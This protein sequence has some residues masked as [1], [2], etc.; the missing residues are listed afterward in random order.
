MKKQILSILMC[1]AL[2]ASAAGCSKNNGSADSAKVKLVVGNWPNETNPQSLER[3]NKLKDDFM[4]D[5][6]DIEIIPDTY[7]FDTKTFVM[8][9]SANQLPNVYLVP[10]T[11]TKQIIKSGYATPITKAMEKYGYTDSLNPALLDLVRGEDNEIYGIPVSAYA[12]GLYINKKLFTDAGLVNDDGSIKIPNTYQEM[13]EY[14]GIIKEKTGVAGYCIPTTNNCGGWHFLNIAWS[15]GVDFMEERDD[16]TWEAT[17]NTP[18]CVEAL[19]YIKD[20]K[21][22]YNA[23]PDNTVIDQKEQRK[24]FAVGQAGMTFAAPPHSELTA[25]FGMNKDDIFAARMPE[26]PKGRYTQMGGVI[27]MLANNVS[28]EQIDATMKWLAYLGY[29]PELTES[30][31]ENKKTTYKSTLDENG[32]VLDRVAFPIWTSEERVRQ[33]S[34]IASEFTNVNSADYADYY[35]FK[36][37]GVKPEEP[38]CCQQL[39]SILDGCIQEV[40]T[41]ENADCKLL[42][43]TAEKDFQVNH[44]DKLQ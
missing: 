35:S 43:E 32:I 19:Q 28:N 16:G 14:A 12:Q 23:L 39:Y 15:W 37:V 31:V 44:L 36:D 21:W 20:L 29:A 9:A 2:A 33:E 1:A 3:Q 22:K 18:E 6:P 11:E 25:T 27:W 40:I 7:A 8:K 42:I 13:A 5:N 17:F 4:A 30:Q 26:G 34:D 24:I 38:Q 10:Y 41:N